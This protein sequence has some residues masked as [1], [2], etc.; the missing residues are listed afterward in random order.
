MTF[1]QRK[2][3]DWQLQLNNPD[4]KTHMSWS[5]FGSVTS[6]DQLDH[7]QLAGCRGA[8]HRTILCFGHVY[9]IFKHEV[10]PNTYPHGIIVPK[11]SIS[12]PYKF[13]LPNKSQDCAHHLCLE[14]VFLAQTGQQIVKYPHIPFHS[15]PKEK[16][17]KQ[18]SNHSLGLQDLL[19]IS[20]LNMPSLVPEIYVL[21]RQVVHILNILQCN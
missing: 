4:D 11:D 21:E 18:P 5:C 10:Y 2:T 20:H 15:F 12:K 9:L 8:E 17:P 1:N 19:S 6:S 13:H 7:L 3:E 14:T 16:L